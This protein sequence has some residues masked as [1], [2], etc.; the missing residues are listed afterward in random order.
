MEGFDVHRLF[1]DRGWRIASIFVLAL[2]LSS[3]E[4]F[5]FIYLLPIECQATYFKSNRVAEGIILPDISGVSS[6]QPLP[7]IHLDE[8]RYPALP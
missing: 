6:N 5:S 2:L 4:I 1:E 8:V 3:V 7:C